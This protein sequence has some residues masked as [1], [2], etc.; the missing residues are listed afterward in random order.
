[1][2]GVLLVEQLLQLGGLDLE[3]PVPDLQRGVFGLS[4][5]EGVPKSPELPIGAGQFRLEF[6]DPAFALAVV[7]WSAA[8][9]GTW[10]DHASTVPLLT[11]WCAKSR[12]VRVSP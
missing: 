2:E 5:D 10:S 11:A 9:G 1:M 3:V 8:T 4:S 7:L 6:L 12:S